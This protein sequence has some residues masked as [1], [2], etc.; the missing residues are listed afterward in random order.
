MSA[1]NSGITPEPGFTY[2]NQLLFY[3]RD[4]VKSNDGSTLPVAGSNSVLMDLNSFIWVA[5]KTVLG[6]AHYSAIATLPI[7]KNDLTSDVNG[8]ISGGGGFAD[9]FYVPLV[10]GWNHKRIGLR[11]LYGFLAPTGRFAI[12]SSNN[13][14][15]GYWTQTVSSGQTCYLT[16]GKSLTLS[17]YEMYEFHTTQE[18]TRTHP[19]DTFDL[20]YSMARTFAFSNGRTQVHVGVVGYEQRQTTAKTGAVISPTQ[21]KER[22]AVNAIGFESGVTFPRR[23]INLGVKLFEELTNR[24]TFQGFSLQLSGGVSF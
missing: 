16:K 22:Y 1:V 23:K 4:Q 18:S 7:A 3:S 5:R 15:S 21:S 11:V 6:G 9:S 8:N 13:V 2:A 17:A 12:G 14:G 19:G 20:D 24:A 10:L